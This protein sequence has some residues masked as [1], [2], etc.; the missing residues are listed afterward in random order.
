MDSPGSGAEGAPPATV[1]AAGG[2][3][4]AGS[5]VNPPPVRVTDWIATVERIVARVYPQPNPVL[6]KELRGWFRGPRFFVFVTAV[7]L[8]AS[9]A[10][11]LAIGLVSQAG[12]A[13]GGTPGRW[14]AAGQPAGGF[15][16]AVIHQLLGLIAVV[17]G[18]ILTAGA[19][20]GERQRQTWELLLAT[21]LS[22]QEIVRGKVG[23]AMAFM[24]LLALC[25]LPVMSLGL[26]LGGLSP[27]AI[28]LSQLG[29]LSAAFLYTSL[30]AL[31][32]TFTANAGRALVGS[33]AVIFLTSC[34]GICFPMVALGGWII[35][36]SGPSA[37]AGNSL[38]LLTSLGHVVAGGA[39]LVGAGSRVRP[40]GRPTMLLVLMILLS[41]WLLAGLVL[42]FGLALIHRLAGPLGV[43]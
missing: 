33:Y 40:S 4:G 34:G 19:V 10:G 31:M 16:V 18:P 27:W 11:W 36:P 21:P 12:S 38:S 35:S 8:S 25:T 41:W 22:G 29:F 28:L 3:Q 5:S 42:P 2:A 9:V 6:V 1:A 43:P 15:L 17:G 13:S 20:A 7:A 37:A 24:L 14:G 30:G 26:L 23:A 39:L 32:S